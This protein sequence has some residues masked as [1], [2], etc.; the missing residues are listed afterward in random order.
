MNYK[1]RTILPADIAALISLCAAHA[2][3]EKADFDPKGKAEKLAKMLFCKDPQLHCLIAENNNEIVEYT[4][5]NKE[6][7]TWNADYYTQMDCLFICESFRR[8][9]IGE[10]LLKEVVAQSKLKKMHHVEWQTQ[11][12][13]H[14]AISFYHKIG[15]S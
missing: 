1:I 8:I 5:F 12:F 11:S 2:E 14:R 4:S 6:C 9:G 13:N 15:A 3:Y 7:S 10:A